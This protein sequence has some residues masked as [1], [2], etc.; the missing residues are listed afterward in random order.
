MVLAHCVSVR[1]TFAVL[2]LSHVRRDLNLEKAGS[3][4]H[5]NID[6]NL[7]GFHRPDLNAAYNRQVLT[8]LCK[9]ATGIREIELM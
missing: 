6:E 7:E 8:S 2:H 3:K 5:C 1:H 9:R 4:G